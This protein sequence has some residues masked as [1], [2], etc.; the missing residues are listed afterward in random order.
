MTVIQVNHAQMDAAAGQVKSTWGQLSNQF[1][2]LQGLVGRLA[3]AWQG[4]DQAAYAGYQ[5]KWNDSATQLNQG[6]QDIGK[7]V[8]NANQNFL[9]ATQVNTRPWQV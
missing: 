5:K 3:Q 7:G 9:T 8:T 4:D 1:S 2:D 6:L